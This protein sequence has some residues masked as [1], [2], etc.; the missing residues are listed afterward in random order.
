MPIDILEGAQADLSALRRTDPGVF[1]L[2]VV[3]LQE[4]EADE[5]LIEKF[6][7]EGEIH[8]GPLRATVKPWASARSQAN[9]LRIRV[10]DSPLTCYRVIYGYDWRTRRIGVLAVVHKEA[11][12][13]ELGSNL[14]RRILADWSDA[15]GGR[16]T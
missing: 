6:T 11:F 5:R 3:F 16:P 4:A 12:N 8:I 10:L 7:A 15:T 2:V 9:L 1:A 13:Y 14:G